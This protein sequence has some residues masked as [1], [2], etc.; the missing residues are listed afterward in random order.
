MDEGWSP[1]LGDREIGLVQRILR[2]FAGATVLTA[3]RPA[4]LVRGL[5]SFRSL[6]SRQVVAAEWFAVGGADVL[7]SA[8]LG[9]QPVTVGKSSSQPDRRILAT[10]VWVS[11]LVAGGAESRSLAG[12]PESGSAAK[13]APAPPGAGAEPRTVTANKVPLP[14]AI[15][16]ESRDGSAEEED[17]HDHDPRHADLQVLFIT[18]WQDPA[19]LAE[20]HRMEAVDGPFDQLRDKGWEVGVDPTDNLRIIS[21]DQAREF[22]VRERITKFPAVAAVF[23]EEVI[24]SFTSGCTTPLDVYTFEWMRTGTHTRPPG[25]PTEA[26]T[27][28]W[29]GTYPLRGSHWSVGA[30]YNPSREAVLWHLRGANHASQIPGDWQLDS[31]SYEE[32]RSLHDDLHERNSPR[33]LVQTRSGGTAGSSAV[34]TVQPAQYTTTNWT[35]T[36]QQSAR[37]YQPAG[38]WTTQQQSKPRGVLGSLFGR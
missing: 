19:A 14:E 38:N 23:G 32:L 29:T 1:R 27:V 26:A 17:D 10:I 16:A 7:P 36:Y 25:E 9:R 8:R 5:R 28:S 37:T 18:T 35:Y 4:R 20:L 6:A 22:I 30:D 12:P 21:T 15:P 33:S 11:L 2:V 24:R 34:S 31:W 3:Q 13:P